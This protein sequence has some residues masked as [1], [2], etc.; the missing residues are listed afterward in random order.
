M[1]DIGRAR[2]A[3]AARI[4]EGEGE[5]PQ[6]Q[7]RAAFEDSELAGPMG[8]LI[9][10]VRRSAPSITDEDVASVRSA[11]IDEDQIFEMVVCGAVGEATR[12][13]EGALAALG[14]AFT[15]E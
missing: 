9:G 8:A 15:E 10:K 13:Y 4:L 12:L 3:L 2:K 1:P 14:A 7:R 11:G 5:A 6:A